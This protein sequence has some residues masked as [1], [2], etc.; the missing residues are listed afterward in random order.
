LI[1]ATRVIGF[2]CISCIRVS[3]IETPT[4]CNRN[5]DIVKRDIPTDQNRPSV[6]M[7]VRRSKEV[8]VRSIEEFRGQGIL[9]AWNRDPR[10][11]EGAR[12]VEPQELVEDRWHTASK[13][14]ESKVL[15][16]LALGFVW[17]QR[18]YW[19]QGDA[20]VA[21]GLVILGL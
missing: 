13:F 15:N 14:G 19:L 20:F 9:A 8:R 18:S 1:R 21:K 17:Y 6:G 3:L 10:Y 4:H 16:I 2:T 7:R 12:I 5:C 11:P